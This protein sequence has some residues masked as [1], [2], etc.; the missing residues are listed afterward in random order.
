MCAVPPASLTTRFQLDANLLRAVSR[1]E[2]NDEAT[3]HGHHDCPAAERVASRRDKRP[4]E[5]VIVDEIRD[6]ADQP[7][8]GIGD[9]SADSADDERHER[10]TQ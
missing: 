10:E 3:G 4:R 7:D 8:E 5:L 9:T 6:R 1:H 2:S